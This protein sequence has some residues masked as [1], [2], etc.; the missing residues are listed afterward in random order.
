M[1]NTR[2][3]IIVMSEMMNDMSLPPSF[4]HS[5][6]SVISAIVYKRAVATDAV[7]KETVEIL[8]N[9]LGGNYDD[10]VN[11]STLWYMLLPSE[12]LAANKLYTELAITMLIDQEPNEP[13]PDVPGLSQVLSRNVLLTSC[14]VLSLVLFG[15]KR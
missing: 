14:Y 5:V 3:A 8:R 2:T 13:L 7:A 9:K 11:L 12:T 10:L 1:D 15:K 6:Q 4:I